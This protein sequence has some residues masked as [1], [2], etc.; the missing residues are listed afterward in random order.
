[1]LTSI[2]DFLKRH[3]RY[4]LIV[5]VGILFAA[6]GQSIGSDQP[7]NTGLVIGGAILLGAIFGAIGALG[8]VGG[9]PDWT[10]RIGIVFIMMAGGVGVFGPPDKARLIVPYLSIGA[11]VGFVGLVMALAASPNEDDSDF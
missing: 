10:T 9:H 6:L 2:R 3:E 7:M 4:A 11:I 1:M 8:H 5:P